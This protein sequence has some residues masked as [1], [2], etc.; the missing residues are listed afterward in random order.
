MYIFQAPK[1]DWTE[2]APIVGFDRGIRILKIKPKSLAPSILLA[3]YIS[4]GK[5][6]KA[7]LNRN[8]PIALVK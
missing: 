3:S 2:S 6:L 5:D 1:N 7:C 4:I 8:I